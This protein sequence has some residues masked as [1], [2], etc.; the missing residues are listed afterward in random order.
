MRSSGDDGIVRGSYDDETMPAATLQDG[1]VRA[2]V[3]DW[4]FYEVSE[5]QSQWRIFSR[6]VL[7][8]N[9]FIVDERATRRSVLLELQLLL[10]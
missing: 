2:S 1:S 4:P 5:V 9:V 3:L 6:A 7:R 8:L 10:D